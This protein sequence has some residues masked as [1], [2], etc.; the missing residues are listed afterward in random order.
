MGI[1]PFADA[2]SSNRHCICDGGFR[3]IVYPEIAAID[4][5][6]LHAVHRVISY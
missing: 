5:T 2:R 1:P 4:C 3:R 6:S